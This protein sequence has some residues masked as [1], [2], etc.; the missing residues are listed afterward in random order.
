MHSLSCTMELGASSL[1][2]RCCLCTY[3]LSRS[4]NWVLPL[5]LLLEWSSLPHTISAGARFPAPHGEAQ[6]A[7]GLVDQGAAVAAGGADAKEGGAA[8]E[9][10]RVREGDREGRSRGAAGAAGAAG[11]AARRR[12]AGTGRGRRACSG[13][14]SS[15]ALPDS[16]IRLGFY[17]TTAAARCLLRASGMTAHTC[18]VRYT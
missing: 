8:E 11:R 9:G 15:L 17:L 7:K 14:A 10:G 3:N 18:G 12:G 6:G 13:C 1:L 4:C 16:V 5:P 2:S